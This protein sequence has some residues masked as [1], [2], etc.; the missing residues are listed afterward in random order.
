MGRTNKFDNMDNHKFSN[1][2][3]PPVFTTED[4]NLT[5]N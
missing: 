5:K 1:K 2:K 3:S 4:L